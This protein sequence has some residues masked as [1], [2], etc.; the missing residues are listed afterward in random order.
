MMPRALHVL[1]LL[2]AGACAWKPFSEVSPAVKAWARNN[3]HVIHE[4]L[5]SKQFLFVCGTPR[6]GVLI[7]IVMLL[8]IELSTMR[9]M[10]HA[11]PPGRVWWR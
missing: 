7:I 4:E 5:G 11:L 9:E 2:V 3:S 8:L 1:V 6:S 10:M